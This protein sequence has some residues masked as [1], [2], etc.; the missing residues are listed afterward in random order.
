MRY[1]LLSVSDKTGLIDLARALTGAGFN[2]LSSGGTARHLGEAG[3]AVTPVEDLTGF[4][5]CL[6]GR[7]KTL[8]PRIAGG[9][10]F[11]RDDESHVEAATRLEMPAIDVVVVNLYPFEERAAGRDLPVEEAVELIDIGG[12]TLIRAAAKNFKDVAVL[13]APSQYEAVAAELEENGELSGSTRQS[14]AAAAFTH[15]ARYDALIAR[16]MQRLDAEEAGAP[17]EHLIL[18]LDRTATLRYGENPHQVAASYKLAGPIS[19]MAAARKHQGKALSHNNLLDLD[20]AWALALSLPREGVAVIKHT[21]PCG[22]GLGAD[23]HKS[24]QRAR[25]CD[26]VSA[27]GGIVAVNGTVTADLAAELKSMFLEVVA[28]TG[29]DPAALE[30]L[31]KKKNLRVMEMPAP[32]AVSSSAMFPWSFRSMAGG[33]LLQS[34]DDAPDP[35]NYEV[36]TTR[37]P[38]DEEW[39]ALKL[40]W[41]VCRHIKSNAIVC[42]N[43]E[44]TTAVGAGQMSRVDSVKICRMKAALPLEGSVAAS[45]AFF[46]FRDG[47]DELAAAGITAVIQPGGSIRDKEVVAAADE[48]GMAM[49]MTGRRHFRH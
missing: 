48:L 37:A 24:F 23:V 22:V 1:A 14:L 26:P 41:A 34:C 36:A 29:F 7:V 42:G 47:V 25:A 20:A 35:D 11:R 40:M 16:T 12:P 4:P 30:L 5:E 31:A 15:T 32:G 49:V 33:A 27:F 43:A 3:L 44:G 9:I 10:L 19:G 13:T 8:N 21:N 6:D 17:P 46:P 18:P 28:A 38:T 39:A 45:D 2:L